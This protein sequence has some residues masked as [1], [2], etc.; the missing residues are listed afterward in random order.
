ME[1][2]GDLPIL[3]DFIADGYRCHLPTTPIPTAISIVMT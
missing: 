2:L 1:Y 3:Q